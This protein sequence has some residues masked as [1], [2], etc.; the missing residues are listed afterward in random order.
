MVYTP[1]SLYL[2][3]YLFLTIEHIKLRFCAKNCLTR[4]IKTT[5]VP[6]NLGLGQISRQVKLQY[7]AFDFMK[8][9]GVICREII[10]DV[11]DVSFQLDMH[12]VLEKDGS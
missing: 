1:K 5:Q 3:I 6:D 9:K 11:M 12:M 2:V 8:L 10:I 4:I 7:L